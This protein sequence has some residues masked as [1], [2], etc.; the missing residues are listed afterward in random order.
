M[1]FGFILVI[2]ACQR[3]STESNALGSAERRSD[4]VPVV[5]RA[6]TTTSRVSVGASSGAPVVTR[7]Q[8]GLHRVGGVD[9]TADPNSKD[10]GLVRTDFTGIN[11]NLETWPLDLKPERP[12]NAAEAWRVIA[13]AHAKA[14]DVSPAEVRLGDEVVSTDCGEKELWHRMTGGVS[15]SGA[16]SVTSTYRN[17]VVGHVLFAHNGEMYL[18]PRL[19]VSEPDS[20]GKDGAS[21]PSVSGGGVSPWFVTLTERV[22][23]RE[24]RCGNKRGRLL[25]CG[26]EDAGEV[27]A[28]QSACEWNSTNEKVLVFD[29]QS[30]EG[31]IGILATA[32]PDHGGVENVPR[33]LLDIE[34]IHE[35]LSVTICGSKRVIPFEKNH[36]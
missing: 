30:F 2:G 20:C 18:Y 3:E 19:S 27:A 13:L 15:R 28:I 1:G 23:A 33:A 34:L 14:E 11:C 12:K 25:P 31:R 32:Q 8:I 5:S 17:S 10:G 35:G 7:E 36:M 22:Y 16:W 24:Y 26:E 6:P 29:P 9:E 4:A 21:A